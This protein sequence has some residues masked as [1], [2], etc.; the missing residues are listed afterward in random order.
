MALEICMP[1]MGATMEEGTILSWKVKEGD[2]VT[3]GQV[4]FEFES[5]K[6]AFSYE[7]PSDGVVLK[8]LTPDGQKAAVGL[9]V[10]LLGAPGENITEEQAVS[11]RVKISP[12][13]RK[14][15]E[16]LR[17]DISK[18]KGSGPGGRIE[19]PDVE[20]AAKKGEAA[21]A[22]PFSPARRLIQKTVI[23]AKREIPHFYIDCSIDMSQV[24]IT[25]QRQ[26]LKGV[27]LSYNAFFLQAA[28]QALLAVPVF[29][30]TYTEKG[31]VLKEAL[32]IALAEETPAGVQLSVIK[33]VD[34]KDLF[35]LSDEISIARGAGPSESFEIACLTISNLGMYRVE[36]L[37]PII[38]PNQSAIIGVGAIADR[39]VVSGGIVQSRSMMTATLSVD[40]RIADG[41]DAARFLEAFAA[42][43]ESPS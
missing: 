37:A 33:D 7:S 32:H 34:R 42:S 15:A 23:L 11:A 12:R 14:L 5:D 8:I 38:P 9:A 36:R 13:A 22:E 29:R 21:Q 26:L 28:A 4:L 18:I 17:V 27:K 2:C 30:Q 6:S 25:R 19:S 41:A 24:Q 10:A 43:L 39:P 16:Q 31:F 1:S 3:K 40:H 20:R 35:Q